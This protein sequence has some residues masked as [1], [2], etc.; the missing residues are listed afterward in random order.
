[1]SNNESSDRALQSSS[2]PLSVRARNLPGRFRG[3]A[4]IFSV[5]LF[6]GLAPS[7]CHAQSHDVT[8]KAGTGNFE[9]EFSTGVK[10]HVGAARNAGLATRACEGTLSWG[11]INLAIA[12]DAAL[13]DVDTV[14]V[15]L[16]LGKS[17]ATFQVQKS[18]TECCRTYQIYSLQQP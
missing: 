13:L 18:N 16:G 10:V 4:I 1:M 12:T 2:A 14:G 15:D 9:T 17:V 6:L 11:K 5:F 8:C 7:V 3:R